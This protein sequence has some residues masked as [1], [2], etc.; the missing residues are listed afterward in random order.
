MFFNR[1]MKNNQNKKTVG[2]SVRSIPGN[3]SQEEKKSVMDLILNDK[4]E[5]CGRCRQNLKDFYPNQ[6]VE[7]NGK[8]YCSDCMAVIKQ[9]AGKQSVCSVCGDEIDMKNIHIVNDKMICRNCFLK[10]YGC[11]SYGEIT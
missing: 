3:N 4:T 2:N 7:F 11:V 5:Y 10:K 6:V 8:K 1:F 9:N